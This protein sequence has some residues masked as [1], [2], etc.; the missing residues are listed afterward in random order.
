MVLLW[1]IAVTRDSSLFNWVDPP[2]SSSSSRKSSFISL[3]YQ[4]YILLRYRY[5]QLFELQDII[6]NMLLFCM[7]IGYLSLPLNSLLHIFPIA[8]VSL[9]VCAWLC[10][11]EKH[12]SKTKG[13]FRP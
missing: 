1:N 8:S 3:S 9:C 12:K 11:V 5:V 13:K 6:E 2:P 4:L 10:S 7:Y